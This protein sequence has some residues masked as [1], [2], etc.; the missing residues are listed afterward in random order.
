VAA[1][2]L[3]ER[4]TYIGNLST[5]TGGIFLTEDFKKYGVNTE[6]INHLDGFRS[7][8]SVI[9]LSEETASRTCV[10]D[11]GNLPPLTL[12]EKHYEAIRDAKVLMVD[13]NEMDAALA[14]A[15]VARECGVNVLYDCGGL[16][17]RVDELLALTDVM[18]PSLEFAI[19]HTGAKDAESAAVALY[20]KYSPKV[21]VVT[22]GVLGGYIYD[23]KNLQKYPAFPVDAKDSNGSGDVFHGAFAAGL[24]KGYDYLKCC[25]YSSATSA[26]KCLGI[27]ARESV[28]SHN[29]V[30]AFLKE[31][32]YEF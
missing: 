2:K 30:I 7:F 3:G 23:G 5:D 13:G 8:T 16:Y 11:R 1:A 31:K 15:K 29:M 17:P 27:G 22:C 18:I 6:L 12:T 4:A 24:A 26:L 10:F 14:G 25:Y 21:V 32:G 28:P 19:G 9:W 20:E